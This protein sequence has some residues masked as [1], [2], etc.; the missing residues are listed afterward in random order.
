MHLH[1][2]APGNVVAGLWSCAKDAWGIT[3]FGGGYTLQLVRVERGTHYLYTQRIAHY[4]LRTFLNGIRMYWSAGRNMPTREACHGGWHV[5]CWCA[6]AEDRRGRGGWYTFFLT[7]IFRRV[8]AVR[9]PGC[10]MVDAPLCKLRDALWMPTFFV[11]DLGLALAPK[12]CSDQSQALKE[13]KNSQVLAVSRC[14]KACLH[15]V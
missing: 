4:T 5:D 12:K 11:T 13:V 8:S 9:S 2:T 6:E 15:R 1:Q 3:K 10:W 7:K 14:T